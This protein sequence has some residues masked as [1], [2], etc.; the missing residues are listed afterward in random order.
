MS[1][2]VLI[3][4]DV[5]VS[6]PLAA[7][8]ASA[9]VALRLANEHTG[10]LEAWFAVAGLLCPLLA[11][12][13]IAFRMARHALA[14]L[15]PSGST[16]LLVAAALWA[17]LALPMTAAVGTV[18][19]AN[20]HHRALGGATFAALVLLV[21]LGA[22]LV[23][24]RATALAFSRVTRPS[25]RTAIALA[26]G[27]AALVL[28]LAMVAGGAL[29]AP[30]EAGVN[31]RIPSLLVDGAV[32]FVV[33]TAVSIVDLRAKRSPWIGAGALIF[34]SSVGLVLVARSPSLARSIASEAPLAGSVAG[35]LGLAGDR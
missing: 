25:I 29:A 12:T 11:V 15:A 31:A 27:A 1:R 34:V 3:S 21:C 7:L 5:L 2:P 22:A 19:K 16:P 23:A 9:P 8:V 6:T 33:A 26:L 13:I 32:A 20:T 24:W 18:L 17:L 28:L 10:L 35:M 14:A 4:S 30:A